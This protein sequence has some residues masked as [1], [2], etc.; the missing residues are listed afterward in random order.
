MIAESARAALRMEALLTGGNLQPAVL[1]RHRARVT[2]RLIVM[3]GVPPSHV[4][5]GGDPLHRFGTWPGAVAAVDDP[6][7][8]RRYRFLA[9]P[10]DHETA[11]LLLDECPECAG[12]QVPVAEIATLADLGR[13]LAAMGQLET[14]DPSTDDTPEDIDAPPVPPEYFGDP[15]HRA[16]CPAATIR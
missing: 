9:S 13:Y 7:T 16:D 11:L 3:L 10:G 1:R 8:G 5:V 4:A 6:D 14:S 15:G 12:D 2:E